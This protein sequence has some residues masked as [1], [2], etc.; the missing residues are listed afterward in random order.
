MITEKSLDLDKELNPEYFS[1]LEKYNA[2]FNKVNKINSD[3]IALRIPKLFL[4][5]SAKRLNEIHNEMKLVEKEYLE[6]DKIINSFIFNPTLFIRNIKDSDLIFLHNVDVLRDIR[7]KLSDGVLILVTNNYNRAKEGQ[8]NQINFIIAI[9]SFVLTFIGLGFTLFTF[10][11]RV[12]NI[13]TNSVG[14]QGLKQTNAII[15]DTSSK[16]EIDSVNVR[17]SD[18]KIL[19]K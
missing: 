9:T 11:P 10:T 1:I 19:K 5:K 2:L 14:I 3:L 13:A 4:W 8:S 12:D 6:W 17:H 15:L 7:N 18:N 16:N